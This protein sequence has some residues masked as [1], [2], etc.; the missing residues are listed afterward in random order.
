MRK[1]KTKKSLN[2]EFHTFTSTNHSNHIK[3][4]LKME[5]M[6]NFQYSGMKNCL[7]N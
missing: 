2:Y 6:D 5:K 4:K 7:K 1:N 3:R